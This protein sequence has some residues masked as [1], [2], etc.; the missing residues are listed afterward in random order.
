MCLQ[1]LALDACAPSAPAPRYLEYFEEDTASDRCF[2]IVQQEARGRSLA[3]M[4]KSGMRAD[5]KEVRQP[6]GWVP[7]QNAVVLLGSRQHYGFIASSWRPAR[8]TCRP[9]YFAPPL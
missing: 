5:E 4:L 7:M 6:R 9:M 2:F 1:Q 8:L 3:D